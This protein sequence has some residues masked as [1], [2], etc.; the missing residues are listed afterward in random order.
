[1]TNFEKITESPEA[2]AEFFVYAEVEDYFDDNRN[3][4]VLSKAWLSKIIDD[5]VAFRTKEEAVAATIK[6]LNKEAEE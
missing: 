3:Y 6:W 4:H 5:S 2:L 1:M